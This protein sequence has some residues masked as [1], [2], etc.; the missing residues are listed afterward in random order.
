MT[1]A[2]K[3]TMEKLDACSISNPIYTSEKYGNDEHGDGSEAKPFK[4]PLQVFDFRNVLH[5]VSHSGHIRFFVI[6][7]I[8]YYQVIPFQSMSIRKIRAK[9][10]TKKR[11]LFSLSQ[12]LFSGQ[13][14]TVIE[15]TRKKSKNS[16]WRRKTKAR[17]HESK[18][19]NLKKLCIFSWI[20]V[21]FSQQEDAQRR[22]EKLGEAKRITIKEDT[23]LPTAEVV[24]SVFFLSLILQRIYFFYK[25]RWKSKKYKI[26]MINEWKFSDG[27]IESDDKVRKKRKNSNPLICYFSGKNL[28][29]IILRDGTGYL[30][31]VL[32][33]I[34]VKLIFV[35]YS[36][37][38]IDLFFFSV[39][40]MIWLY[41]RLKRL[42]L[43][44]ALYDQFLKD[45]VHLA[46][47]N[48][49]S[50]ILK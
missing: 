19:S 27:Y 3:S 8:H 13:M 26:I 1:T 25:I 47:R 22:E 7:V 23:S 29:F 11:F 21:F 37:I 40:H 45:K 48:S 34:L 46:I 4:T 12:L 6:M 43:C 16:I 20:D 50:I 17:T 36:D 28:T 32:T 10:E 30:Q 24:R 31:C 41:C 35:Q 38:N 33:G 15:S 9:Y 44:V 18:R 42:C 14:G 5:V 49:L 2:T 39:K